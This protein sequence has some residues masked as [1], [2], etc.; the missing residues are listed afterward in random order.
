MSMIM[1]A[2]LPEFKR[3][4]SK[5]SPPVPAKAGAQSQRTG[6]RWRLSPTLIGDGHQRTQSVLQHPLYAGRGCGI[7]YDLDLLVDRL[8]E[9]LRP[10]GPHDLARRADLRG[11]LRIAGG[12]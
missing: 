12:R 9:F 5:P 1:T 6:C 8:R 2:E 3:R 4:G 10:T 7:R 11:D